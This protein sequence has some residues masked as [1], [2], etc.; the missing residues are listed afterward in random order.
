MRRGR[1]C[2]RPENQAE[3]TFKGEPCDNSKD[4]F[5]LIL[6]DIPMMTLR[7]T[8]KTILFLSCVRR[9]SKHRSGEEGEGAGGEEAEVIGGEEVGGGAEGRE[10]LYLEGRPL[11]TSHSI[12]FPSSLSLVVPRRQERAQEV[13]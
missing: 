7:K 6:R 12:H 5:Q 2:G 1:L 3:G 11:L 4:G 13:S 8:S 10:E 9:W